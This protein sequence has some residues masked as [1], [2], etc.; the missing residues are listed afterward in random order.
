M[1]MLLLHHGER[2]VSPSRYVATVT[3]PGTMLQTCRE[4]MSLCWRGVVIV[5]GEIPRAADNVLRR[6]FTRYKTRS[7]EI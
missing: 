2:V 6:A 4:K 5:V 3:L 1:H 7:G